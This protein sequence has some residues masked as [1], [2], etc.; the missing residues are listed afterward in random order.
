[1]CSGTLNMTFGTFI[2]LL[3]FE[4]PDSSCYCLFHKCVSGLLS[5][6]YSFIYNWADCKNVKEHFTNSVYFLIISFWNVGIHGFCIWI[7]NLAFQCL[8]TCKQCPCTIKNLNTRNAHPAWE[9]NFT[10]PAL[11]WNKTKQNKKNYLPIT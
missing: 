3:S 7:L 6:A 11:N 5:K 1:M 2:L 8:F 10:H 4:L 9:K